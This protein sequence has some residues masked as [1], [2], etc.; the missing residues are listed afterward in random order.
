MPT[1]RLDVS[2]LLV[3]RQGETVH[4]YWTVCNIY[5]LSQDETDMTLTSELD[6]E[7]ALWVTHIVKLVQQSQLYMIFY[8]PLEPQRHACYINIVILTFD[9]LTADS[10]KIFPLS[11]YNGVTRTFFSNTASPPD[12]LQPQ[13]GMGPVTKKKNLFITNTHIYIKL[14]TNTC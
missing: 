2:T 13:N 3:T 8:S 10:V 1:H 4:Q 5:E 9:L 7:W 11:L 12:L 6:L 14:Q